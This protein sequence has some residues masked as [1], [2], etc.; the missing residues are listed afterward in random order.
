MTTN[1]T[2]LA[3]EIIHEIALTGYL[4]HQDVSALSQTCKT[5]ASLLIHDT[6]GHDIHHALLGVTANVNAKNW[7]AARYA[8]KRR[9]FTEDDVW[10]RVVEAPVGEMGWSQKT[11]DLV[12][13][14]DIAG[15]ESVVLPAMALPGTSGCLDSWTRASTVHG[16]ERTS[17]L[18]AAASVGS[19]VLVRWVLERGGMLDQDNGFPSRTPLWLA[20]REGHPEVAKIL[21]ERGA[22]IMTK[23]RLLSS[24]L[25]AAVHSGDARLVLY[26]LERRVLDVDE[27]DTSG[28]YP[29]GIAC[30]YGHLDVVVLLVE[31]GGADLNLEGQNPRGPRVWACAGGHCD[32]VAFLLPFGSE[33]LWEVPLVTAAEKGHVNVVHLLMDAGVSVDGIDILGDTPLGRASREGHFDVVTA[34]VHG[35]GADI[36]KRGYQ[37][38][39]PLFLACARSHEHIV[40]VLVQAGADPQVAADDGRTAMDAA[41]EL[42]SGDRILAII[43][44]V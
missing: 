34:L 18:H 19:R 43:T 21:V 39:T 3:P 7:V 26:L 27:L 32:V 9:W 6:Y 16:E 23:D 22:N 36:N 44:N 10:K 2:T 17:L 35:G 42:A 37:G 12:T 38:K 30:W 1:I 8:L 29:L 11:V 28:N 31:Q 4:S 41:S 25:L 5:M 40:R 33:A 20:C 13:P 15:W 24:T 14:E